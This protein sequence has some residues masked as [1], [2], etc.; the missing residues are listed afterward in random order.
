MR[1]PRLRAATAAAA[2]LSLLA[3]AALAPASD[4]A[5][6]QPVRLTAALSTG[7]QLGGSSPLRIGLHVNPRLKASPVTAIEL[8]YPA[9]LG[10]TTSGLGIAACHHTQAQFDNVV[11]DYGTGLIDCPRN[12]VIATGEA[13]GAIHNSD[14]GA[15]LSREVGSITVLSGPI[16]DGHLGLVTLV[17]G[18][19]PVGAELVYAGQIAPA[20]APYGGA[21]S[22]TLPP[23]PAGYGAQVAL[24]DLD[25]T[26]GGR[27]IVY[28][29]RAGGRTIAYHPDGI[30]LPERCPTAG[31]RFAATFTFA[32]GS[33]NSD[34]ARAR[35]P[36]P[37]GRLSRRR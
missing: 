14:D 7:A 2:S 26:L 1:T 16:R 17:T 22:I 4:A 24:L 34:T 21:L 20:P 11:V 5:A 12:A 13:A 36:T 29:R 27:N 32:D 18:W 8:R 33:R 15:E 37:G 23:L 9:S 10:I 31:F 35:C 30:A 19:H 28:T 3:L 6:R 25:L